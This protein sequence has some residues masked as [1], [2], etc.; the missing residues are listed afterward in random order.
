SAQPM[1]QGSSRKSS[2][3]PVRPSHRFSTPF[4]NTKRRAILCCVLLASFQALPRQSRGQT[5]SLTVSAPRVQHPAYSARVP[6]Q[7]RSPAEIDGAERTTASSPSTAI[8]P[9]RPTVGIDELAASKQVGL[10][11]P[12]RR[13]AT[14]SSGLTSNGPAKFSSALAVPM[15]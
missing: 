12:R 8:A 6:L 14:T 4:G 5:S 13:G 2:S 15:I 10:Y 11:S 1:S 7:L 3:S 9:F